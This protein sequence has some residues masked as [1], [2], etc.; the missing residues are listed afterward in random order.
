MLLALPQK[1]SIKRVLLTVIALRGEI[2]PSEIVANGLKEFLETSKNGRRILDQEQDELF[3]WIELFVFS[4]NPTAVVD[5][6]EW[7]PD[8][9]LYSELLP[10]LL[11][12][13]RNCPD[14]EQALNILIELSQRNQQLKEGNIWWDALMGLGNE[15]SAN[16]LLDLVCEIK[17][18]RKW[19]VSWR[20]REYLSI[21]AQKFPFL[22]KHI[23]EL[24]EKPLPEDLKN[25]LKVFLLNW[26]IPKIF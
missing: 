9:H 13:V 1:Y 17:I 21:L 11:L 6:L 25:F 23:I 5:A 8:R 15:A 10:R 12:A 20:L 7:I 19:D 4:D 2:I 24:Y 26:P 14:E 22:R 16:V 3:N 18:L